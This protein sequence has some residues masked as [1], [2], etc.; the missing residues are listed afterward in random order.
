VAANP[1][2][3]APF[4]TDFQRNGRLTLPWKNWLD[5]ITSAGATIASTAAGALMAANNLSDLPNLASAR[6]NLGLGSAA[7]QPV[8]A[9][10]GAGA[11]AAAQ[12][13]A[14]AAS[15][16]AGSAA[17]VL[18]SSLQKASNLSD[19]GDAATARTNLGLGS[20][21]SVTVTLAKLTAG[22]TN[23]SLT[24]VNGLLTAKVDPV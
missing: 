17:A 23:G 7:T 9:F 2:G 12:A 1:I 3:D 24:F 6:T 14:I 16:A 5:S 21:L 13:A 18:A 4:T 10:D 8:T 15:D 11:A 20:G 22:G 19:L